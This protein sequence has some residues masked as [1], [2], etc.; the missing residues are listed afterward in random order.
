MIFFRCARVLWSL[1][2]EATTTTVVVVIVDRFS[3][4]CPFM[5]QQVYLVRS[6]DG[7]ML[8]SIGIGSMMCMLRKVLLSRVEPLLM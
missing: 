8:R 4:V 2:H 6:A 7:C 3:P 1:L 5:V